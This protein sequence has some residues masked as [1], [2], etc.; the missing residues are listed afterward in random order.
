MEQKELN[1]LIKKH[2]MFMNGRPGGARAVIRD[3]DLSGLSFEKAK[4][5]QSDFTGCIMRGCDLSGAQFESATLFGCDMTKAKLYHTNFTRADLRGADI[6]GA[7]LREGASVLRVSADEEGRDIYKEQQKG[8]VVLVGSDLSGASLQNTHATKADFG[9]ANLSGA[10]LSGAQLQ[11]ANLEGSDMTGSNMS[12]T[13]LR[14]ANLKDSIMLGVD[15]EQADIKDA[16]LAGA[17]TD[18]QSGRAYE[19]VALTL[20]EMVKK[21]TEWVSSAGRQGK[22]LNLS[23]YDMR[24]IR[25]LA[26]ARLTAIKAMK[27][28]FAGVNFTGTEMQSAILDGSD[29]RKCD[30]RS[31]DLR[32][33]SLKGALLNRA[34]MR[35]ANLSFLSFTQKDGNERHTPCNLEGAWLR[36]TDLS[37]AQLRGAILRNADLSHA[38]LTDCDLRGTDFR[39]ADLT[40]TIFE[41]A[42][43]DGALFDAGSPQAK[44]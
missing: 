10:D 12:K 22:Q 33:S 27:T 8:N 37:G 36:Y 34:D 16:D 32:A 31:I 42:Q 23:D 28:M 41:H 44:R 13:D 39:G 29:F 14:S 7:D 18:D 19:E 4:L 3:R 35:N 24:N 5:S 43:T 20:D 21:H 1:E 26:G 17:L 2:D 38:D 40:Q 6:T 25:T 30:M 11:S 9:N 15:L